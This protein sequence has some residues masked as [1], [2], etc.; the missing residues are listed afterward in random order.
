LKLQNKLANSDNRPE[1]NY[2]SYY[3]EKIIVRESSRHKE[4]Y[5]SLLDNNS[6][7]NL[8][9]RIKA[10]KINTKESDINNHN[11]QNNLNGHNINSNSEENLNP[12]DFQVI[13][14]NKKKYVKKFYYKSQPGKNENGLSKI[15]QDNFLIMENIL[16]NDE[17]RIFGVFDGHGNTNVIF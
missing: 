14:A 2:G 16:N 17:F 8:N 15:N 5:E 3:K 4:N 13:S 1:F 7:N 6:N 12:N 9:Y 11:I 10:G